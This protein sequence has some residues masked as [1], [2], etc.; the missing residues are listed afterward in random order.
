MK[1]TQKRALGLVALLVTIAVTAFAAFLPMPQ[2]QATSTTSVTD[3]ITVR[4]VGSSPRTDITSPEDESVFLGPEQT[5]AYQYENAETVTVTLEY[6]DQSGTTQTFILKEFEAG[7]EAGSDSFGINLADYGYG[8]FVLKV[9]GEGFEGASYEA[10]IAFSYY[11]MTIDAN[12]DENTGNVNVDLNYDPNNSD[13]DKI[14]IE[15]YDEDGN[16]IEIDGVSPVTVNPPAKEAI[17][18]FG[19]KNLPNGEYKIVATAYDASGKALYSPYVKY[20][21]YTG[22]LEPVPVPNTGGI[23]KDNNI[24]QTDYLITGLI[25][26][27]IVAVAGIAFMMR[28]DKKTTR[29]GKSGRRK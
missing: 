5:I 9:D 7:Y 22:E 19:D 18:K 12:E 26:F 28:N 6:T 4:V 21:K 16:K 14:V 23:F 20:L 11:P 25:I 29:S 15:V 17:L 2:T 3:T 8:E 13:I 27:G 10:V 24:S 1:K